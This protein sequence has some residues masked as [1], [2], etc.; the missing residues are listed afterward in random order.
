M[1]RLDLGHARVPVDEVRIRSSTPRYVRQV[2]VERSNDGKTFSPL[3]TGQIA[4]F[5]GV[6]LSSIS[7]AAGHRF[8]RVTIQNGD[9]VLF[10]NAFA[11]R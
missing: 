11:T 10:A 4:R 6:E 8:I 7:L 2:T 3:S 5:P 9:D 1:V